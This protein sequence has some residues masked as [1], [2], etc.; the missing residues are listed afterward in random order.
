MLIKKLL[1]IIAPTAPGAVAFHIHQVVPAFQIN[2]DSNANKKKRIRFVSLSD[3]SNS[4]TQAKKIRNVKAETGH[5]NT[6]SKPARRLN[7]S[8]EYFFK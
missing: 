7:I 6:N 3:I 2:I 1:P 4:G 5:A 8:D